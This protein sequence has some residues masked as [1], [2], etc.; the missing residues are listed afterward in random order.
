MV[1]LAKVILQT[2]ILEIAEILNL[3]TWQVSVLI[4]PS[5]FSQCQVLAEIEA[6]WPC[7]IL[8]FYFLVIWIL[9]FSSV[10]IL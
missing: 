6:H 1:S 8:D 3:S 5:L 10:S 4:L 2:L 9:V 7:V